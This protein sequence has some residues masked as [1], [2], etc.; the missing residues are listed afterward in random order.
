MPNNRQLLAE[1]KELSVRDQVSLP[2]LYG[3]SPGFKKLG[4]ALPPRLDEGVEIDETQAQILK[5]CN[6]RAPAAPVPSKN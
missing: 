2:I 5:R 1:R 3:Q 4:L 6:M